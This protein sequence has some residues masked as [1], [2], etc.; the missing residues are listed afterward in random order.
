MGR[1]AHSVLEL[2]G[3]TPLVRLERLGSG[4]EATIHL[5]LEQLNPGGSIKDRIALAMIRAAERDGLLRPGGTIVEATA[6]NTGVGLAQV[7]ASRGYRCLFV[8]PD[9][10]SDEKERLLAAYGAEIVRTRSDVPADH[11]E[12]YK[13]MAARLAAKTPGAWYADQFHN[14]EN[15]QVHY[16]TTGPEIWA[17]TDGRI[18]VLV[19]GMGTTGSL[20]GAGRFLKERKPGVRVVAVDPV[21]SAYAGGSAGR[22][23]VEGIGG[24]E[25]P[26]I[27]DAES[28]DEFLTVDDA[29]GFGLARRL[30]REE[31][32]LVGGSSGFALAGALRV[33]SALDGPATIVVLMTD[34]GRN[35]LSKVHSDEWML[36]HGLID[37]PEPAQAVG[38]ARGQGEAAREAGFATR[39]IHAGQPPDPRTGAVVVPIHPA[40]T[41]KQDGI[42]VFREGFEY[43]R[44]GNPTRRSLEQTLAAL[45]GAA[46]GL[47]FA[48]GS[49]ATAAVLDAL[50]PGD[51]VLTTIDVYGGTYRLFQQVYAK[52]G[53]TF[54]FLNTSDARE[55]LA[56]VGER[57]RLI[58]V[59]TP[60]NPLLNV[61]DVAAIAH[62]KGP[63]VRLA[64][65]N[66]FASPFL[67]NPL[68][69]GADLVVHSATKYLG[70]HSDVVGGAVLTS[71][72]E[73]AEALAFH[74]NAAGAVPS[75][76]D[77][78]LLQ[79][80]VKTLAVRM[81]AHEQNARA[82]AKRLEGHPRVSRVFFP[83]LPSH[84][85]HQLARRQMRGVPGMV[86]F[87][88]DGGRPAVD[89]FFERTRLFTL[90]E[91]LGGVESLA[92]YPY[93]MTHGAIPEAEKQRIGISEDLIRLSV[94]IEEPED[95]LA[96]LDAALDCRR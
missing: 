83:G 6:G 13:G 47:C 39:A 42:G 61:I 55:I 11:P 10:M 18:D 67:Q 33:A 41:F 56:E 48:S 88:I 89:A 14:P 75:P 49:A 87:R 59:E 12:G 94:G 37:P 90:A 1:I 17:D 45:E 96:D 84:P 26:E 36:A 57:T 8:M 78:F 74:Q 54:R 79:R 5:K 35:Y 22:Y 43:S 51:E 3:N 60:T 91:S 80:G 32:L 23:L 50:S 65:D 2:I 73:L 29:E 93:T 85:H 27:Y 20:C 44:T 19:G 7:A 64:V 81:R 40:S 68:A 30:A 9:K 71:D 31:G 34:T 70:G 72:A 58:W 46:H 95:L 28:I 52:Y 53:I 16:Q 25:L 82:I 15:P 24:D 86:S 63:G 77:C 62:G 92:C 66:T 69:L 76:F 38:A 4:L 21:G